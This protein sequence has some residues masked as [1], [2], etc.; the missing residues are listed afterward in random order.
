MYTIG[1]Q[2]YTECVFSDFTLSIIKKNKRYN[3]GH[4]YYPI[5]DE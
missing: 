1:Y 3:N 2:T 4:T 5:P